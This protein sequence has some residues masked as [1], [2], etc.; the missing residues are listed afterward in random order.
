M[1]CLKSH[2]LYP[3]SGGSKDFAFSITLLGS[4]SSLRTLHR[5]HLSLKP[6]MTQEHFF[7]FP[8]A[9]TVVAPLCTHI[10]QDQPSAIVG[11]ILACTCP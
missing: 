7:S 11:V 2:S 6:A 3:R 9:V 10:S 8:S 4:Y 1:T 5:H